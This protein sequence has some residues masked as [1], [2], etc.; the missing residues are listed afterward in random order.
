[1]GIGD[2]FGS[3]FTLGTLLLA[4]GL[5]LCVL[6]AVAFAR[7]AL[8]DYAI[9]RQENALERDIVTMQRENDQLRGRVGYLNTDTGIELLAREELGWIRPGDTAVIV[10]TEPI[11]P[12]SPVA[13]GVTPTVSPAAR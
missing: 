11:A 4:A 1:M 5:P 6:V 2:R 13:G 9:H 3:R 8:A 10:I 7:V 12:S